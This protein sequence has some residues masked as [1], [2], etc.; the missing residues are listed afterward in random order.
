MKPGRVR[1]IAAAAVAVLAG[2]DEMQ[3]SVN[4]AFK[5]TELAT[6]SV[7]QRVEEQLGG[8]ATAIDTTAASKL[9]AAFR[10]AAGQAL[11]AVVQITTV[12]V[13]NDETGE[14][15]AAER[16]AQGTGSGFIFDRR[17]YILTNYHVVQDA[18]SVNVA[19]LDGRDFDATVVG[20]D[21][22]TDVAVVRIDSKSGD[23]P[24]IE[25]GDSDELRVG[26][27]V[28]ALGNPLGLA[29]TA[30]AGIVSAKNRAISILGEQSDTPLESFIQTDAAINPG[31]SGGPL[32][33]L[34][35]KAIGI[36][37]AIQSET[38]FYTGA[39][40]AVP[41]ALARKVAEDLLKFGV[42]HRPRLGIAIE[43]VNSADAEVYKLK[44][45]TGAEIASVTKGQAADRAGLQLGDVITTIEDHPIRGVTDLQAR[46]ALH[47]PGERITVGFVRY[48]R[49]MQ[50]EVQLG[51]FDIATA[52]ARRER[53]AESRNPIGF[54]VVPVRAQIAVRRGIPTGSPIVNEIDPFGPN[55]DSGL[56]AGYIITRFNGKDIRSVRDLERAAAL[57]RTGQVVTMIAID[58]RITDR[59][60]I[61]V[62]FRV[63]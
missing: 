29:F 3:R 48:G 50:A 15:G 16:R 10:A 53:S 55:A 60:P 21:P 32:V 35:G 25:L 49:P 4:D 39:G 38:G 28:V 43:D 47:Q 8:P 42:V 20:A 24:V 6:S 31:N 14:F 22:S 12:S 19:L 17:G 57:V 34:R 45:V 41:I 46:V 58:A 30:T 13:L 62:N 2:C 7:D 11:P 9:S 40:F 26:D 1:V 44:A 5:N 36:N 33:D 27:W 59:D 54:T 61:I 52:A 51:E 37:T 63:D 18:L 56:R 23:L